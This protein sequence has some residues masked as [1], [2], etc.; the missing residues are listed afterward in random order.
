MNLQMMEENA[1][2]AVAL[3]KAMANERRLFVL[4]LLLEGELSVGQIAEKLELSQ[5]ALSQHLGWLRKDELVSTRKESQT[6]FYS[7][8][9]EEVKSVIQLLHDLYCPKN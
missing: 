1:P 6:V 8:N 4:C 2:Q 7:L 3:L 9:S 5:S